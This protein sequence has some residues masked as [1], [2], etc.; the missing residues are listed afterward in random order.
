[1]D[2]RA[3]FAGVQTEAR[4][5]VGVVG[6]FGTSVEVDGCI[7]LARGDDLDSASVEKGTEA[8]VEREVDGLLELTAVEVGTGV[9][10]AMG[11]VEDD[12]KA[13]GGGWRGLG[14]WGRRRRL[15]DA[16]K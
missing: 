13:G 14:R 9:V 6:K 15:S 1:M 7:R 3:A 2:P 4:G 10:T 5:G 11:C 12:D 16:R 8:D